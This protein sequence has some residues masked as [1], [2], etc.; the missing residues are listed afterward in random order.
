MSFYF[1]GLAAVAWWLKDSTYR[2]CMSSPFAKIF[3][4]CRV[5]TK[6]KLEIVQVVRRG[7]DK[8]YYIANFI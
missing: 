1:G 5:C 6:H 7:I 2:Y 3:Y 8:I 4:I